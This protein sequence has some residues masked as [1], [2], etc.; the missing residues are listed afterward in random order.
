MYENLSAYQFIYYNQGFGVIV[1]LY[2]CIKIIIQTMFSNFHL[3]ATLITTSLILTS[4]SSSKQVQN[5][6]IKID[7]SLISDELIIVPDTFVL[8]DMPEELTDSDS[9][10]KYLVMHYW[11]KFN[12]SDDNLI[13][14]PE[15]T[16]QAF[17][18][19]IN[20]LYYVSFA[21]AEESLISTLKQA[22]KNKKMYLHFADLFD[23]YYYEPN[24][25]F[26]NEEFYIPVLYE[27]VSNKTLSKDEKSKYN[28]QLEMTKRNRVGNTATDFSYTLNT[29][30]SNKMS[31]I[32]SEYLIILFSNPDCSTC[33]AI[34]KE[35]SESEIINK[36]FALNNATR[37][38]ISILTI[39]PDGNI[40]E[41]RSHLSSLPSNWIN[42]Y[43]KDMTITKQKLYDIKAIPT[44][45]LLDKNK[46]VILKDTSLETIESFFEIP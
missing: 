14:K 33:A 43:D 7:S 6:A 29:G 19:Y 15:I 41:W 46:K 35:L 22:E 34:T 17:V 18:D 25:P 40:E 26:R 27:L 9:R 38:M 36:A 3:L 42:G 2:F 12:F 5:E 31:S 30:E 4:C 13:S 21:Q 20:I 28:F 11:D 45:Y 8:P 10:A 1:F 37:T 16:E 44:I 32:K 23:K 24:S 39:Y